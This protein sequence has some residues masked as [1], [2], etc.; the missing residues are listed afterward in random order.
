MWNPTTTPLV[1]TGL[2]TALAVLA[3]AAPSLA[4]A[5]KKKKAEAMLAPS[6]ATT[7]A[8]DIP[9][10]AELLHKAGWVATPEMTGAFQA[11]LIFR[12]TEHGHSPLISDCFEAEPNSSTYTS[13]E[14]VS[15]LQTGVGMRFGGARVEATGGMIK[16]VKFGT[17]T[18]ITL[19]EL[20]LVPTDDCRSKIERAQGQGMD[21]SQAYVI[22]QVLMAQISE[23]TCGQIDASGRFIAVG[24]A[25]AVSYTHL[26]LPTICSV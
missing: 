12:P 4:E 18:H 13:S 21:L 8:E 14:V 10:L 1:P 15:Q 2:L 17:P 19:D 25:E 7:S 22:Q 16:K 26:T 20:S 23:Q 3:F 5:G 6:G 24:Q 9:E 11:G